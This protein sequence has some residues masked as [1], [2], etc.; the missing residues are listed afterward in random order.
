MRQKVAK[1]TKTE[2]SMVDDVLKFCNQVYVPSDDDVR[3]KILMKAYS[4]FYTSHIK[5]VKISQDLRRSFWW[6]GMKVDVATF[7]VKCLVCQ[8]VNFEYQ[9]LS[10]LLNLLSIPKQKWEHIFKDFVVGPSRVK[11]RFN[12]LWVSMDQLTKYS[13]H[14]SQGQYEF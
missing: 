10:R 8:Q 6:Y 4:S 9:R 14:P 7:V 5:S 2:F 13:F 1:T 3:H 12:V 11:G